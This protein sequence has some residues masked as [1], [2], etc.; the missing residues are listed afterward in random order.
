MPVN[1]KG[2]T[3]KMGGEGRHLRII[4]EVKGGKNGQQMLNAA[5]K[6]GK[7]VYKNSFE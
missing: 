7:T 3:R 1:W 6:S 4:P 2:I 5:E